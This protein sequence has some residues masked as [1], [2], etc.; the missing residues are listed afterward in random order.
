M[1]R[2]RRLEIPGGVYHVITRGI[3]RRNIFLDDKDRAEFVRRLSEGIKNTGCKCYG[4]VLMPNHIHLIIQTGVKP[5]SDLM[6]ALLTGYAIHFNMRHKRTGY[7]YQNR[8]KSILCQK[9]AYL[10]ELVRYVHLNPLRGAIVKDIPELEKYPW[11]GHAVLTGNLKNDWQ[12]VD[13]ILSHFSDGKQQAI[14]LYRNFI[15]D[16]LSMNKRDDLTGGGLRRSAGGWGG[17]WELK[18]RKEYWRGDERV[19]GDGNFVENVLKAA[20]K[21]I[22]T[23]SRLKMDGWNIER[24]GKRISELFSVDIKDLQRKVRQKNKSDAK[25]VFAFWARRELGIASSELGE[26]LSCSRAG[27][28]QLINRGE[29]YVTEKNVKLLS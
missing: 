14:S 27:L 24:L 29:K 9:D 26:F 4:W 1:P 12:N 20:E 28:T 25:A 10:F 15:Q 11:A 17:V 23:K 13:E 6:R 16:G 19:L 21:E 5:L 2:N 3:E 18:Q 8:Y 7:L 22:E